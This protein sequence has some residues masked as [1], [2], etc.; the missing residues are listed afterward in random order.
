M[1]K[2]RLKSGSRDLNSMD[3]DSLEAR[4]LDY[5]SKCPADGIHAQHRQR[6]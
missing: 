5:S 4:K 2:W 3:D 1:T 6:P